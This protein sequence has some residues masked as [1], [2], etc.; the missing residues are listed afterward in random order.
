MRAPFSLAAAVFSAALLLGAVTAVAQFPTTVNYQVMLTDDADEPL[1]DQAVEL[2][3]RLY[4]LEAGGVAGWTETH[5]TTTNSIG[6]VS[7]I[8]G[9]VNPIPLDSFP[10]HLWLEIEVDGETMSPRRR[11]TSAPYAFDAY[12]SH[13]LGGLAATDYATDAELSTPG[14]INDP[15]NL[16][17]WTKLKN[18]PS[19]FADGSDA[20][21]GAGDGYSLDAWDGDPVDAVWVGG[22]GK[23]GIGTTDPISTLHVHLDT[24]YTTT[25]QLTNSASGT[26]ATDGLVL[27]L[28][29]S[30]GGAA[31]RNYEAAPLYLGAGTY[32]SLK[33]NT[34]GSIDMAPD[35][36]Q[37]GEL[38]IYGTTSSGFALHRS[39]E[40]ADGG[41][42]ELKDEA[43][44]VAVLFGADNSHTGGRLQVSRDAVYGLDKGVDLNGNWANSEQPALRIMGSDRSANFFMNQSGNNSV[45]LPQSAVS[46][47]EILDEPGVASS[48]RDAS[49]ALTTNYVTITSR[50]ITVPAGGYVLAMAHC[51]IAGLHTTGGLTVGIVGISDTDTGLPGNQLIYVALPTGAPTGNYCF[52]GSCHGLFDVPTAGTY[53]YYFLGRS[54]YG[55]VLVDNTQFTLVY[56]PTAYGTVTPTLA[57]DA[58]GAGDEA[59]PPGAP[60]THADIAAERAEAEAFNLARIERELEEIR[61]Q[62]E[63]MKED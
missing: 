6:V 33:L 40:D 4:Q 11:L 25:L 24:L 23:V 14:S 41:Q 52:P 7:V 55:S 46:G 13:Q 22:N 2:V 5:N 60:L 39:Y 44:N 27:S 34:D 56:F 9:T 37:S 51:D 62:V 49:I 35:T 38:N 53:T 17:D 26:G 59:Q 20:E 50:S 61:A 21:G 31:V 58:R 57:G 47:Y 1:A 19:G 42:F 30:G 8:L 28:S 36:A 10:G 16:V 48:I 54:S 12:N 3:F 63:A 15:S 45:A 18:V 29:P 32:S 43:G